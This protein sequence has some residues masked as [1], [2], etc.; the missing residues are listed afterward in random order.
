MG[1]LMRS[2]FAESSASL[3][4]DL[5]NYGGAAQWHGVYYRGEKIGF[6][7]SETKETAAGYEIQEE[8]RLQMTL[9]GAPTA[10]AIKTVARVDRAFGL[11]SFSFSLDPGSGPV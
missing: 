2:V 4:A 5:G 1:A 7:V 9:L 8:G 10:A 3:A 6:T 11:H